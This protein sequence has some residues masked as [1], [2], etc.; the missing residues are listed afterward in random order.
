MPDKTLFLFVDQGTSEIKFL[1]LGFVRSYMNKFE[2]ARCLDREDPP[3]GELLASPIIGRRRDAHVLEWED[4]TPDDDD[5]AARGAVTVPINRQQF[6]AIKRI[7]CDKLV[8][9]QGPPGT[10]K[11]TTIFNALKYRLPEGKQAIVAAV[12]NQVWP[13]TIC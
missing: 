2:A 7:G 13:L 1:N 3:F 11:S 5:V 8:L 10:G 4:V 9:I 12:T 6:G